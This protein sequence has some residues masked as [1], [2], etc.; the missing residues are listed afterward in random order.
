MQKAQ[1]QPDEQNVR[2]IMM[3]APV[4]L[5]HISTH[6]QFIKGDRLHANAFAG[7][8]EQFEELIA[9]IKEFEKLANS[10]AE[11][12]MKQQQAEQQQLQE[13]IQRGDQTELQKHLMEVKAEQEFKVLKEQHNHAVRVAKAQ[14][15]IKLAQAKAL[16][17]IELAKVRAANEKGAQ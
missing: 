11:Q 16:N 1:A 2:S 6:L 17:E 3:A 5:Q 4:V 8:S 9:G 13:I 10:F 7:Y 14:N 15:S 12:N